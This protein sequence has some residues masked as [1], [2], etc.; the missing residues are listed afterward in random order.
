M[1]YHERRTTMTKQDQDQHEAPHV[2]S[3]AIGGINRVA[4]MMEDYAKK[5]RQRAAEIKHGSPTATRPEMHTWAIN[6]IENFMRNINFSDLAGMTAQL[7]AVDQYLPKP[8]T[9]K[10]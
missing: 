7:G 3:N 8:E 9:Y 2:L 1:Q 6:E 5:L 10:N 4:R